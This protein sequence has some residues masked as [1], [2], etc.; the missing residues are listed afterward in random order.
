MSAGARWRYVMHFEPDDRREYLSQALEKAYKAIKL[1][2]R[3][4]VGL[5]HAGH[6]HT[7][8]AN[9]MSPY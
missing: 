6:V 7:M 4:P 3:D 5:Y 2:S 1:D 9:M 8:P